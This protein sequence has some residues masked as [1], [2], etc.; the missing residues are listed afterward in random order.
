VPYP[1]GVFTF[2]RSEF[3]LDDGCRALD[4]GCGPGTLS[5]PLSP[6]VREVVALDV[7]AEMLAEGERQAAQLGRGNIRWLRLRA[8]E[9]SGEL[10]RFRLVTLGQSFHWMDRDSVLRR[11]APLVEDGGGLALV[12]PGRRRPQES[13]E[14]LAQSVVAKYLG[15]R[16]RHPRANPEPADEPALRRSQDFE[17]VGAREFPSVVER[18][19]VQRTHRQRLLWAHSVDQ[20]DHR[21]ERERV[22]RICTDTYVWHRCCGDCVVWCGAGAPEHWDGGW[23]NVYVHAPHVRQRSQ[24]QCWTTDGF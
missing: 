3:A 5:I 16:E 12:A 2:L 24:G 4:L 22:Q 9:V 10:G 11:L 14:A 18:A 8:E 13:W 19:G 7:D 21:D 6:F 20:P 1:A 23:R 15:P 17:E